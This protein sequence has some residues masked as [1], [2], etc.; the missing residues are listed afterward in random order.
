MDCTNLYDS[1][2]LTASTTALV[3]IP[4]II[5]SAFSVV[6]ILKMLINQSVASGNMFKYLLVKSTAEFCLFVIDIFYLGYDCKSCGIANTFAGEIWNN[7]FAS[8]TE[9]CLMYVSSLME[10]IMTFDCY[11]SLKNRWQFL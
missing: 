8:Y 7:Y 10:V 9:I 6:C 4:G 3:D 5:L 11:L 2:P 1:Y